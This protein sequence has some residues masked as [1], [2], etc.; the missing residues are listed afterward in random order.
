M[1]IEEIYLNNN[2]DFLIVSI[3][4]QVI[5]MGALRKI[6]DKTA[7]IKRIRVNIKHQSQ[8]IG[9]MILSRLIKEARKLGYKKVILD[10]TENQKVAKKLYEKCG[11]KE[12]KRN[13]VANLGKIYYKL[14][15]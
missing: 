5:G 3:D 14:D 9:L 10:T 8:G 6:N 7:E 15:L 11:F 1:N 2:G 4:N 13:K 12:F